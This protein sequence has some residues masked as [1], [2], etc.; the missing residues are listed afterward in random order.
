MGAGHAHRHEILAQYTTGS[1]PESN[2][3]FSFKA[4]VETIWLLIALLATFVFC[5]IVDRRK[6]SVYSRRPN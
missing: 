5:L 2:E 3:D 1:Y 4:L 6:A